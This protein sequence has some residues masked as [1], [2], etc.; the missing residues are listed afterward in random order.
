MRFY[1]VQLVALCCSINLIGP[2]AGLAEESAATRQADASADEKAIREAGDAYRAAFAK[3]DLEAVAAFWAANADLVDQTG[4]AF[5][6]QALIE[7]AR[8][9]AEAGGQI[10]PPQR[11][12][13]TL[14][15][16]FITPDVALEDGTFERGGE[17]GS[18]QGRY[19]AVWVKR[20]GKWLLDGER[21]S[22]VNAPAVEDPLPSLAW[23]VGEWTAT[24]DDQSAEMS[25]TWGPGK[26][27]L[28]R[29]ITLKP[30]NG[31]PITA[32]QW[33]GWDPIQEQLRSFLFDSRGGFNDGV[34]TNE[35]DAWV[36]RNKG[37]TR[38]G[39]R[40][41]GVM[42][43]SRI[44]DNTWT[45][46]SLEDEVDGQPGPEINLRVTRKKAGR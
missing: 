38:D 32:T 7:Q 43:Y 18:R 10:P 20:N 25:C 40:S 46:E 22:P 28:L 24:G 26:T 3:G 33:I 36:V 30:K 19:T 15:I 14:S 23:M 2:A 12:S 11:K 39:T 6:V 31:D 13:T 34:W 21:E 27:Y 45:I 1:L 29:Q 5:K 35:G 42:L 37:T 16:R 44:D 17:D 9:R 8:K 41:S 4:H